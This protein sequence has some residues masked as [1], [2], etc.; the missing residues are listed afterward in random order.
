LK[1]QNLD[2]LAVMVSC[3]WV[4]E[5]QKSSIDSRLVPPFFVSQPSALMLALA[6]DSVT[7]YDSA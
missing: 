1:D 3:S 2:E 7:V 4:R 5:V 6:H